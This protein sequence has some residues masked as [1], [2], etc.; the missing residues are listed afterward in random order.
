MRG[1]ISRCLLAAALSLGLASAGSA[2]IIYGTG[3]QTGALGAA[4]ATS[5]SLSGALPAT[6]ANTLIMGGAQAGSPTF[7]AD[8]QGAIYL[9][10]AHGLALLGRGTTN[11]VILANRGAQIA[12]R[13]PTGT[14]NLVGAGTLTGLSGLTSSGT[15]TLSGVT[16]GTNTN[17]ACFAAGGVMTLQGS[18]CTISSMR[19]K[20]LIGPQ[21]ADKAL[22]DVLKLEPI[23]FTMKP[24]DEP[25][26]DWNYDKPQIGLSAENVAAVNPKCAIYE[27][28]GV[29]PKSYRQEC[30]IAELVGAVRALK[31]DNDSLRAEIRHR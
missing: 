7:T 26:P 28:D 13:V 3:F 8:G 15:I 6:A 4:G 25:N 29:T 22:A 1:L 2:Q 27:Q 10:T 31:A 20:N 5:L 11:D 30:V 23:A 16:T 24:G 18:A 17:F 9:I 14:T 21:P 19:F 12:L